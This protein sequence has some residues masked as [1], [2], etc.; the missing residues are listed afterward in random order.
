MIR[1]LGLDYGTN[2]TG[3]AICDPFGMTAQ[4]LEIIKRKDPLNIKPTIE[5]ISQIC[6]EYGVQK[7]VLGWPK[8]MNN[9]EG[10]RC[11]QTRNF[12][13]KLENKL[14]IPVEIWDERLTTMEAENL[15][16]S[17]DVSRG[18]RKQVIDKLASVLILQN[19]LDAN[20]V[21][22]GRI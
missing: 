15:L 11:E 7:I 1:I 10:E 3:V 4:G 6:E 12:Q 19:Y 17:A 22:K 21:S 16:I 2:T 5:R 13:K 9:T 14:K 8:N 18:K 20:G